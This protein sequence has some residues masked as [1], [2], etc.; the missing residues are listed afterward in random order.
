[1]GTN[2]CD[3]CAF[4]VPRG[5]VHMKRLRASWMRLCS[6][7][8]KQQ[9]DRELNDEVASH[10]EMHIEDNLRAAMTR[11]AARRDALLKL[12][13]LEQTKEI[14]RAQRGLPSIETAWQDLR[15][16]FRMLRRSPGFSL[17]AILCLTL[18]IGANAA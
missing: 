10:L 3:P 14:Y 12:G 13:G 5:A 6:L 18:G 9:L 8:H 7:F 17:L 4:L 15:F 11:E 1:M 16:G 2:N